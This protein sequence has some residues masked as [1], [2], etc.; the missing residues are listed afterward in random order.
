[1]F[2][3]LVTEEGKDRFIAVF[4][5]RV[6]AKK[7]INGFE[8]SESDSGAL[9]W[10]K[11]PSFSDEPP[12]KVARWMFDSKEKAEAFIKKVKIR[13]EKLDVDRKQNAQ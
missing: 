12:K 2:T 9:W 13:E 8:V 3:V 7:F 4:P 1:M 10:V 11:S 5:S 6:L